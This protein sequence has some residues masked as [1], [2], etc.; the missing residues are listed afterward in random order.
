[1]PINFTGV[2]Q[3]PR[4]EA[5]QGTLVAPGVFVAPIAWEI[6]PSLEFQNLLPAGLSLLVN[7][8]GT[9]ASIG[10]TY[11]GVPL[12]GTNYPVRVV[13]VDATGATARA[14]LFLVTVP[15]SVTITTVAI[16]NAIDTVSY[17][18]QLTAAGGVGP[19]TFVVDPSTTGFI[20]PTVIPTPGG[21]PTGLTLTSGGLIT[22]L[23]TTIWANTIKFVASDS[24]VPPNTSIVTPLPFASQSAGLVITTTQ[25]NL[26]ANQPLS[27]RAYTMIFAAAGDPNTPYTWSISPASPNQ[28][29]AGLSL[30]NASSTTGQVTGTTTATG[31]SKNVLIRV[32]DNIGAYTEAV[33]LFTVTQS[34]ALKTG[35]DFTDSTNTSFLGYVVNGSVGGITT[36]PNLSFVVV[37]SG[38][39]SPSAAGLNCSVGA[40]YDVTGSGVPL[41]D[42]STP[43]A[44]TGSAFVATP[45][46]PIAGVA[47]IL[48]SGTGFNLTIG[49][50]YA[51]VFT[52]TDSGV[53]VSQTF[54]WTVYSHGSSLALAP[55]V[56]NLPIQQVG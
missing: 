20:S 55:S 6:A 44:H 19:Y 51:L 9:T 7:G 30:S 38:V 34:L 41:T 52:L 12:T 47:H 27:G 33:F 48:L 11:S 1:M 26:N 4:G 35:I 8:D 50:T 37:A 43:V 2:G 15:N 21:S 45:Q 32:T 24:L 10:G 3:I 36:R 53:T 46:T 56:G 31:F 23:T 13:A 29:P 22:G 42:I 25:A 40:V 28:L 5:Y 39:V 16:P 54:L 49:R 14:I 18:F 17:N